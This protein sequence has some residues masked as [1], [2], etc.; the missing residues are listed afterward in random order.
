MLLFVGPDEEE[1][2]EEE[3]EINTDPPDS[4]KREDISP[5]PDY[6]DIIYDDE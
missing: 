2:P 5:Y 3:L 4:T 6:T 1:E